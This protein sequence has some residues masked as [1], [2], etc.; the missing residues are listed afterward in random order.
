MYIVI[1]II[2]ELAQTVKPCA[3][4][5]VEWLTSSV[6]E[7]RRHGN[8]EVAFCCCRPGRIPARVHAAV[9][10]PNPRSATYKRFLLPS[11]TPSF[12]LSLLPSV[13]LSSFLPPL[14]FSTPFFCPCF[15]SSFVSS[16]EIYATLSTSTN[17]HYYSDDEHRPS[18]G[19]A[20]LF[21]VRRPLRR[22]AAVCLSHTI[23]N[24]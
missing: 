23:R 13:L 2:M 5:N 1:H 17:Y 11:C 16:A 20:L 6:L 21:A 15:L 10:A 12:R 7:E 8:V 22:D 14:H 18:I 19:V 24:A 3:R 4:F 9:F